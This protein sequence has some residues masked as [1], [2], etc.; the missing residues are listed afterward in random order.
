MNEF[1]WLADLTQ[2][3]ELDAERAE[4]MRASLLVHI[5]NEQL[6]EDLVPLVDTR[7][8]SP[9]ESARMRRRLEDK[10]REPKGRSFWR[11]AVTAMTAV[12]AMI[13][14]VLITITTVGTDSAEALRNVAE[15]VA[16]I[17]DEDFTTTEVERRIDQ[18]ILI[19][20]TID[21]DGLSATEVAF[22]LPITEIQ[23][24]APDGS[25][26][27]EE[28][29]RE[30]TFFTPLDDTSVAVIRERFLVGETQISTFPPST[31]SDEAA[32]LTDDPELLAD[33]INETISRFGPPEIPYEVQVVSMVA[34]IYNAT[35]P[36]SSER[37]A[38]LDVLASTSGLE[39]PSPQLAGTVEV[40]VNYVY[41][42]GTAVRLNII[43]DAQG[44]LVRETESLLD[45]I[46]ALSVPPG[47]AVFD[48]L[49]T[50]PIVS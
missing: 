8:P 34:S 37:A 41:D 43:L 38:L 10:L 19:I 46:D 29:V 30:P 49:F 48:R 24:S 42:D 50:P 45:G 12:A 18:T 5:A 15:A 11:R 2:D 20:E 21:I 1:D 40:A 14:L 4:R 22:L 25:R 32:M 7:L 33:R 31:P 9:L 28:T 39:F 3:T 44:W 23:R 36:T 47:T 35:L 6:K 26:Q 13:A 27:K 16:I 17:P